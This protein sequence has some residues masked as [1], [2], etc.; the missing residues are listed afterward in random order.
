MAPVPGAPRSGGKI[1]FGFRRY[2]A[3]RCCKNTQSA[4][5]PDLAQCKS[6]S[7][8]NMVSRR[9]HLLYHFLRTT[10]LQL[11]SFYATKYFRKKLASGNAH[12]TNY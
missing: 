6:V 12:W 1:F 4:R 8:Y 2:S 9:N 11:S 7:D 3:E 10:R 5:Y